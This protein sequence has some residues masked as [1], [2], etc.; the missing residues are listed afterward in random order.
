MAWTSD[1]LDKFERIT[2]FDYLLL[3]NNYYNFIDRDKQKIYD[4]YNGTSQTPDGASFDTLNK[5]R[6]DFKHSIHLATINRESFARFDDWELF[7]DLEKFNEQLNTIYNSSKYLR[8]AIVN[9]N[10]NTNPLIEVTLKPNQSL[11]RLAEDLNADDPQNNWTDIFLNNQIT[12]ESYTNDGG[13]LLYV[14]F[15]GSDPLVINSVIDNIDTAEKT[16]GRD[17]QARLK[18]ENNNLKVLD[19]EATL[20]QTVNILTGLKRRDNPARPDDGYDP[21]IAVGSTIN[22]VTF[23]AI[24]RQLYNV[25]SSDDSFKS[26]A[27]TDAKIEGD[28]TILFYTVQTKAGEVQEGELRI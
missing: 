13:T 18:F 16:Y 6:R 26:F 9:G 11:E 28:A 14:S 2:G 1:T 3:L 17:I 21:S 22:S 12:E 5:L 23:P 4:Y 20:L 27:I 24:F 7:L 19:Y 25:I 8:S 10:F 15:Q